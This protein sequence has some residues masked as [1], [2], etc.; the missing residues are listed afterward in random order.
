MQ[1][2]PQ[3]RTVRPLGNSY[4][5]VNSKSFH[6]PRKKRHHFSSHSCSS[7]LHLA[8]NHFS[9]FCC[10]GLVCSGYM[11]TLV[12]AFFHWTCFQGSLYWHIIACISTPFPFYGPI[13]IP[14]YGY[15]PQF[16][17]HS[18]V[19]GNV[20]FTF[21]FLQ[22]MLLWTFMQ[23]LWR[24]IFLILVGKLARNGT[25]GL[26]L[27]MFTYWG[28]DKLFQKQLHLFTFLQLCMDLVSRK[29]LVF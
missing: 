17:Y 26:F 27:I 7:S 29:D 11:W 6:Q 9:A 18:S 23:F 2:K 3:K 25:V 13:V 21:W 16:V 10:C 19:D 28:T 24:H 4:H 1:W 5:C 8:T 12:S 22:I 14:L 15:I 20:V